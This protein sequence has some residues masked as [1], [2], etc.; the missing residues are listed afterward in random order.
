LDDLAR[1]DDIV[2]HYTDLYRRYGDD[3]RSVQ[4]TDRPTQRVRFEV[5]CQGIADLRAADLEILDVGCGLGHLYEYLRGV[6]FAGRYGGVD[7]NP[8]FVDA[9][10]RKFPECRFE[11]WDIAAAPP[12]WE[13]DYTVLSGVFNNPRPDA[14]A[15]V[16][17]SLRHMFAASR[18]GVLFNAM[19]TY[20]DFLAPEL[21]YFHPEDLFRF[22][23]EALSPRVCL[24]HDYQVKPGV[25]PF[26]YAIYVY[27][28]DTPARARL[29]RGESG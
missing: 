6:G 18:R 27:R 16:R 14:D 13:A 5:L 12:P 24:R 17:A 11:V 22:C 28:A 20:V 15:F 19:S 1:F 3:P 9:C 2:E 10:R 21:V 4:L 7:V 23:K 29:A 25:V 26:E 8:E